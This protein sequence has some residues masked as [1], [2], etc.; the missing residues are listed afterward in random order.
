[1]EFAGAFETHITVRATDSTDIDALRLWAER[2]NL[3]FHH[4]VLDRGQTPSQPMVSRRGRGRLSSELSAA[5]ELRRLLAAEAF[6]VSRIK[7]EATPQNDDVPTSDATAIGA[8]AGRYFEHHVKLALDPSADIV[9]LA[10]IAVTHSAHLSRNARRVRAEGGHERFVTQR[11]FAVG[12][13]TA[14]EK[15]KSLLIALETLG[16]PIL[17]VEEEFVVYDSNPGVDSGWL[18]SKETS[19]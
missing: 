3:A 2:H 4:I 1:M 14:R 18:E 19:S 9:A 15:L 8:H 7:I 12:R 11:C 16:H 17:S 10:A 13:N 5:D 6:A